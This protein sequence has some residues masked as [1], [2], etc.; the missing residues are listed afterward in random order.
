MK[1]HIQKTE[2]AMESSIAHMM[3]EFAGM[4]TGRASIHLLDS[5]MVNYY[6]S[7][8]PLNQLATI[9]APEPT[10]L[11][12]APFDP[13]SIGEIEKAIHR[14]GL[15]LSPI[16]DGKLVRLPIPPLTEERRKELAKLVAKIAED[17]KTV[18]RN[19]RRDANDAI[20]K[21]EKDKQISEDDEHRFY[22][23]IQKV[24]DKHIEKIEELAEK[25]K[26]EIM[27]V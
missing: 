1:E 4:R 19:H 20:K 13:S 3:K 18:I 27:Q 21:A 10:L 12:V 11:V 9:T 5:V 22:G 24:T 7:E 23:D 15:G 25:K 16:N 2:K 17:T 14:S 6:G 8:V 26:E